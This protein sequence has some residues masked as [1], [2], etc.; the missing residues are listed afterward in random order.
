MSINNQTETTLPLSLTT[1]S[2]LI[3]GPA[4]ATSTVRLSNLTNVPARTF[5]V[6][7]IFNTTNANLP[8]RVQ[9]GILVNK[10]ASTDRLYTL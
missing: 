2:I 1:D 5:H 10:I 4:A 3:R 8:V 9:S 6:I 7:D